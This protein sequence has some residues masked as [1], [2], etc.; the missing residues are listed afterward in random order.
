MSRG[1]LAVLQ[2]NVAKR[3]KCNPVIARPQAALLVA[4]RAKRAVLN[5]T[6]GR[7]ASPHIKLPKVQPPIGAL[8]VEPQKITVPS[9]PMMWTRMMLTA[10]DCAVAVPTP[11]GPPEAV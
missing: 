4:P 9:M 6:G 5:S 3:R 10:I 8:G 11:T 2:A 1:R 7:P